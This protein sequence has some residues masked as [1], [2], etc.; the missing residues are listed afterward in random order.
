MISFFP[1]LTAAADNDNKLPHFVSACISHIVTVRIMNSGRFS[2]PSLK[3]ESI[4][5]S[6]H[7]NKAD[8]HHEPGMKISADRI[9]N[10]DL[11]P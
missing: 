4:K 3:T 7:E 6:V 5:N 1:V 8:L 10:S 2:C 9:E 11:I